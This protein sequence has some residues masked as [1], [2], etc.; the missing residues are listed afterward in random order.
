MELLSFGAESQ[1]FIINET[2]LKK[3]RTPQV[4]RHPELDLKIRRKRAKREYKVLD[5]LYTQKMLVPRVQNL[6]LDECSFE[7][8]FIKGNSLTKH[9]S[10][11][12]LKKTMAQIA[13]MHTLGIVHCDLT[14]LNVMVSKSGE[15]VIIDFGLSEYSSNREERAVDLNV[16]FIFLRNDYPELF[17]YK[18]SLLE[19]YRKEFKDDSQVDEVFTRLEEV[20]K[21][22]RNKNK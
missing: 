14:P 4:Y 8:E 22:G 16:F 18:D 15:I 19:V 2:T 10:L 7:M 20:E 17:A 3:I 12:Y 13:K 21:R 9:M 11:K 5:S 6:N 1:I